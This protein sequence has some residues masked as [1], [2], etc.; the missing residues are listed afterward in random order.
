MPNPK[1]RFSKTRTAK[2]RTHYKAIA[3]TVSSCSNCGASVLYHRVCSEC[4]YYKG[5]LAIEKAATA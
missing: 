3:P 4:G 1:H 2:R 5:K